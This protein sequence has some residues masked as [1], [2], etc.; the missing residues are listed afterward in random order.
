MSAEAMKT[1]FHPFEAE[2]L[3]LPRKGE[4]ILFLGAEPG[5]RSSHDFEATLHL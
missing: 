2:A 1:L 5:L 4:R 3:P